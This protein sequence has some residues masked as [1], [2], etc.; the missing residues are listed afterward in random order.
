MGLF[1][2]AAPAKRSQPAGSSG[3]IDGK[4]R[5][6]H[7]FYAERQ[8]SDRAA[9]VRRIDCRGAGDSGLWV[10]RGRLVFPRQSSGG[11]LGWPVAAV[12]AGASVDPEEARRG[13][14][15]LAG[16]ASGLNLSG[17]GPVRG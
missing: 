11:V 15:P 10:E 12:F 1:P 4:L 5:P 14:T 16:T 9:V 17:F 8:V 13:G 2:P 7:S 3:S 6:A